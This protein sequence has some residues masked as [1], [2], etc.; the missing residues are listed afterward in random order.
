MREARVVGFM[1][2]NSAAPP[3]PKTLPPVCFSAGGDAFSFLTLQF[4]ARQQS[5]F[6]HRRR[7]GARSVDGLRLGQFKTQQT[8]L[9]EDDSAFDG[10]LQFAHI[11]RPV[12]GSEL[13]HRGFRNS[14]WGTTHAPGALHHEMG[15]ERRDVLAAFAQWRDFNRKDA[16]AIEK[17][18][19][20]PA[21]IDLFL[22]VATGSGN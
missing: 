11:A 21:G 1:L 19:A 6:C 15:G 13:A 14:R 5:R 7:E 16:Q 12:V 22:Q 3:G 4:V 20:E 8:S 10:V 17:V 2:S 18:L 9:R